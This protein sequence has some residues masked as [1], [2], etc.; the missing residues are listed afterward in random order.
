MVDPGVS[1]NRDEMQIEMHQAARVIQQRELEEVV[2]GINTVVAMSVE[3]G[4]T[5]KKN[6]YILG[7]KEEIK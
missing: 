6:I 1:P 3:D 7:N 2:V 4:D 5:P